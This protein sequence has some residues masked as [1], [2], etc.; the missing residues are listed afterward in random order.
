M[1][2][3]EQDEIKKETNND[4]IMAPTLEELKQKPTQLQIKMTP[5]IKKN[6]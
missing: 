2:Q 5:L 1:R 4:Y 6:E 3:K